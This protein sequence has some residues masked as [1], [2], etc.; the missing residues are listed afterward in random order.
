VVGVSVAPAKKSTLDHSLVFVYST[1]NAAL[2]FLK[3]G[4]VPIEGSPVHPFGPENR[5]GSDP[6]SA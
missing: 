4:D 3:S 6:R 2:R 1:Y 5:I